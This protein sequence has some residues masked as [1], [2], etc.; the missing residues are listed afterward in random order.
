MRESNNNSGIGF[1]EVLAVVFI[2]LNN[3]NNM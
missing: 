3:C 1:H 2:V